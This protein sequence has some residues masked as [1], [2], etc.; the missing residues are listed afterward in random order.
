[1]RRYTEP[2]SYTFAWHCTAPPSLAEFD[3]PPGE[4]PGDYADA[5]DYVKRFAEAVPCEELIE[6]VS[7]GKEA[8][9]DSLA[10]GRESYGDLDI[11]NDWGVGWFKS[12][13]PDGTPVYYL[14]HSGVEHVFEPV[15]YGRGA[16]QSAE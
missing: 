13:Y 11:A 15:G 4:S 6:S 1:M 2:T 14:V 7:G 5:V 16:N 12:R 9:L 8:V 3:F 10:Y